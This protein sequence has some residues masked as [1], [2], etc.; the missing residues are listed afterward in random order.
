M[1]DDSKLNL[2]T[3]VPEEHVYDLEQI[4][5]CQT[6]SKKSSHFVKTLA[7]SHF[8]S[9]VIGFEKLLV[10][11]PKVTFP[12]FPSDCTQNSRKIVS[13]TIHKLVIF[14]KSIDIV[15]SHPAKLPK[16]LRIK[17]VTDKMNERSKVLISRNSDPFAAVLEESEICFGERSFAFLRST[18]L[19][20]LEHNIDAGF[21]DSP[22]TV[23]FGF[24][25]VEKEE[26]CE[27]LPT[28]QFGDDRQM[29]NSFF[30]DLEADIL[31]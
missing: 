20:N 31:A 29:F 7:E 3:L 1:F 17:L 2:V 6:F 12:A 19:A 21:T 5:F 9:F 30:P 23:I 25:L 13:T 10:D 14:A 22:I 18:K 26:T 8:K 24:E 15:L 28:D 16:E 27:E 11:F 4:S